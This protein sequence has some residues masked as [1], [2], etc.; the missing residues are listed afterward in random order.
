LQHGYEYAL[1]TGGDGVWE[2]VTVLLD[3]IERE[4]AKPIAGERLQWIL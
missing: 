3:L 2:K 1:A 4:L